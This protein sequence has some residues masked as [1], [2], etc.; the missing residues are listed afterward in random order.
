MSVSHG[1]MRLPRQ[2]RAVLRTILE[3][4]LVLLLAVAGVVV[5]S[6]LGDEAPPTTQDSD[7]QLVAGGLPWAER[8][9]AMDET[10]P[11]RR[12]P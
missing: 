8:I 9:S 3:V 2:G 6:S 5:L 10:Q 11:R 7:T 12:A 1:T 4:A